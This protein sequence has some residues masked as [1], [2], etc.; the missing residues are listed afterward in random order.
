M[1]EPTTIWLRALESTY[2]PPR[3][4]LDAGWADVLHRAQAG[5]SDAATPR[6]PSRVAVSLLHRRSA[7]SL[8]HRRLALS[9]PHR[10]LG[11]ALAT[12][13]TLL[14]SFTAL[15]AAAVIVGGPLAGF[16]DWLGIGP[17]KPAPPAVQRSFSKANSASVA[18]FPRGTRLR[19][20]LQRRLGGVHY[21]L[22]GFRAPG[23][24]CLRLEADG[25]GSAPACAP[26]SALTSAGELVHV[27]VAGQPLSAGARSVTVTYGFATDAARR[28]EVVDHRGAHP[29]QLAY[30]AF[31]YVSLDAKRPLGAIAVDASGNEVPIAVPATAEAVGPRRDWGFQ[32]TPQLHREGGRPAERHSEGRLPRGRQ[33][34]ALSWLLHRKSIGAPLPAAKVL[35]L[36]PPGARLMFARLIDPGQGSP[37]RVGVALV[38]RGRARQAPPQVC[39][40]LYQP[41]SDGLAGC[42]PLRTLFASH[43]IVG[44]MLP[45]VAGGEG[46]VLVGLAAPRVSRISSLV[47]GYQRKLE[48]SP[49]DGVFAIEHS[50]SSFSPWLLV[51]ERTRAR[52]PKAGRRFDEMEIESGRWPSPETG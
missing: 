52:P 40:V 50:G 25:V 19:L 5:E 1:S 7:V 32:S 3:L 18:R 34:V 8:P 14:L 12:L 29:S 2:P 28:V 15:T 37:L 35:P 27:L 41:L 4:D 17:G 43:H 48:V 51:S 6:I 22:L 24:L 9:R 11:L 39:E 16:R 45:S 20:L 49:R 26:I 46:A 44:R 31:L 23:R 13:F 47:G 33:P 30:D 36:L 42:A 21:Q 10:S 38:R